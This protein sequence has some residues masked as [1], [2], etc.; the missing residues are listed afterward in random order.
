M[1]LVKQRPDLGVGHYEVTL[2]MTV[3]QTAEHLNFTE[4]TIRRFIW[5]GRLNAK[6]ENRRWFIDVDSIEAL[7]SE[8]VARLKGGE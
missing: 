7:G 5:Q 8:L 1:P 4:H 3:Q 6:K 2:W